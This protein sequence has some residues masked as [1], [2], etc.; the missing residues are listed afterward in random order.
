[1]SS[2]K[3]LIVE[4]SS[5]VTTPAPTTIGEDAHGGISHVQDSWVCAVA[6][7]VWR[8]ILGLEGTRPI[9]GGV[10]QR[11]EIDRSTECVLRPAA[12]AG[13]VSAIERRGVVVFHGQLIVGARIG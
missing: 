8:G 4:G 10:E 9:D 2:L 5:P 1:M 13:N 11:V 12:R 6:V 3:V 7:E